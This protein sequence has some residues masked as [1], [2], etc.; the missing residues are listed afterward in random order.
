MLTETEQANIVTIKN[1]LDAKNELLSIADIFNIADNLSKKTAFSREQVFGFWIDFL[2]R[3]REM[4]FIDT[5]LAIHTHQLSG[6]NK[7][8][9]LARKGIED[10][11]DQAV[12]DAD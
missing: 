6:A 9:E 10:S 2:N 4:G 7:F 5:A 1:L 12:E 11:L 3:D 8:I